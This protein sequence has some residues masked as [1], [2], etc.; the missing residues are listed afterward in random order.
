MTGVLENKVWSGNIRIEHGKCHKRLKKITPDGHC[1]F[2]TARNI[3]ITTG[4][5]YTGKAI[6]VIIGCGNLI[7]KSRN[8]QNSE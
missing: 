7:I 5:K 2:Y 3:V 6:Y 1:I 4:G 8:K